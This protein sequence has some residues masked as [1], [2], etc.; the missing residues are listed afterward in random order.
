MKWITGETGFCLPNLHLQAVLGIEWK[1]SDFSWDTQ[2][3]VTVF[4]LSEIDSQHPFL[5]SAETLQI[6][7]PNFAVT[8]CFPLCCREDEKWHCVCLLENCCS[9]E[10]FS[11]HFRDNK[12]LKQQLI[13]FR[14]QILVGYSLCSSQDVY[15][16][17]I[18]DGANVVAKREVVV[19]PLVFR[20]EI[21]FQ[22]RHCCRGNQWDNN[23]WMTRIDHSVMFLS[24]WGRSRR[25]RGVSWQTISVT[26]EQRKEGMSRDTERGYH[27]REIHYINYSKVISLTEERQPRKC[28]R[29]FE[30]KKFY[31]M[32]GLVQDSCSC[33]SRNEKSKTRSRSQKEK[34]F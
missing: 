26:F 20:D 23:Q 32:E 1:Y 25:E 30:G 33:R 34:T 28:N 13:M 27:T 6:L 22:E 16:G 21:V 2:M 18:D 14:Y 8:D 12:L 19:T 10:S 5:C 11:I 15:D 31:V 29:T 7:I 24:E 4:L 9:L 17:L 3:K